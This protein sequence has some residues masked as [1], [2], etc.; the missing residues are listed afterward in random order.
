MKLTNIKQKGAHIDHSTIW[1]TPL[2]MNEKAALVQNKW[3][4]VQIWYRWHSFIIHTI[5]TYT[6]SHLPLI[7]KYSYIDSKI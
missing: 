4:S 3:F 5:D 6:C 7:V 2:H 1:S